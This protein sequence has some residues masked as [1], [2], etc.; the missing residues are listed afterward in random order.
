MN[1]LLLM[2]SKARI[3]NIVPISYFFF[4]GEDI[5]FEVIPFCTRSIVSCVLLSHCIE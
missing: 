3:G 2:V 1:L 4:V 5:R